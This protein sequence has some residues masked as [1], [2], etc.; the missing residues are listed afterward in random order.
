VRGQ[1]IVVGATAFAQSKMA[2]RALAE[3]MARHP[4]PSGIYVARIVVR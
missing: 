1:T 2:Q 3:S 4:W